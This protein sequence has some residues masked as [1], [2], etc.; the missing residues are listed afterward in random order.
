M[1][2]QELNSH[3]RLRRWD[4]RKA[5]TSQ[6]WRLRWL[7][8]GPHHLFALQAFALYILRDN[9]LVLAAV[10][11][12]VSIVLALIT[13]PLYLAIVKHRVSDIKKRYPKISQGDINNI[14]AKKGQN[15]PLLAIVLQVGLLAA[16][17]FLALQLLG[18]DYFIDLYENARDAIIKPKEIE[19]D[20]NLFYEDVDVKAFFDIELLA[21]I[22]S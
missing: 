7:C 18:E 20:G 19:Y 8:Q 21:A 13:N 15:S 1:L 2:P 9:L 11:I 3:N 12:V 10:I 14:C 5:R 22:L 16:S 6:R 4:F 17:V